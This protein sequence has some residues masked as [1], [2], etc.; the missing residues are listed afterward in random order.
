[1]DSKKREGGQPSA[2]DCLP[3]LM[4]HVATSYTVQLQ[5]GGCSLAVAKTAS[6]TGGGLHR[7]AIR[8]TCTSGALRRSSA[9]FTAVS[10]N[11]KMSSRESA[12]V[13]RK[14]RPQTEGKPLS[15]CIKRKKQWISR[16]L[17]KNVQRQLKKVPDY[18]M[19]L[20]HNPLQHEV[21]EAMKRFFQNRQYDVLV[22]LRQLLLTAAVV[23]LFCIP[24]FAGE[25]SVSLGMNGGD[26]DTITGDLSLRYTLNPFYGN[27]ML[28]I[29][30]LI[31]CAGV[32]WKRDH[33]AI[34]GGGIA[35][36]AVV[37]F[38]REG[39]WRPYVSGSFGGFM[40]SDNKIASHS[41]GC[42]FQFRTKGSAGIRFGESYRHDVQVDVAHFSNAGLNNHNSGFN[43][44]WRFIRIPL[45][46]VPMKR[47]RPT[48]RYDDR[49]LGAAP[50]L[51]L[52]LSQNN[53]RR[54]GTLPILGL[55]L[56]PASN[57]LERLLCQD[58]FFHWHQPFPLWL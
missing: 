18:D 54:P 33:D 43:Y 7:Q 11:T 19:V 41:L 9:S 38:W 57:A 25:W 42:N 17:L 51:P 37:D 46:G 8:F 24:C 36:G 52:H 50:F 30:P 44:L 23:C 12:S 2:P 13:F 40:L 29:R 45:L 28:E 10:F 47:K 35:G 27:D 14:T 55:L 58:A 32:Y 21:L 16:T 4:C 39:S 20:P 49:L 26:A 3:S 1:M 15:L 5:S 6:G 31:E 34:W 48:L 56:C 53:K 22:S